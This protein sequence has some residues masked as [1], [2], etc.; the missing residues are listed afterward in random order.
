MLATANMQ[1]QLNNNKRFQRHYQYAVEMTLHLKRILIIFAT[2]MVI[3]E[4]SK[5]QVSNNYFNFEY[6]LEFARTEV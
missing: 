2:L 5:G 4:V 1:W 6:F 3:M